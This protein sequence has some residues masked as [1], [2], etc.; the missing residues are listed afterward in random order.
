[1]FDPHQEIF[2]DQNEKIMKEL[3]TIEQQSEKMWLSNTGLQFLSILDIGEPSWKEK[4]V[5]VF[6]KKM[7]LDFKYLTWD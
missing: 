1:M 4:A 2:R 7:S 3:S 6:L 5:N